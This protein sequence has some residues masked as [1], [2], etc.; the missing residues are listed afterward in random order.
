MA[1]EVQYPQA[2]PDQAVQLQEAED[3]EVPLR[4][5][6]QG[7]RPVINEA[8]EP[9]QDELEVGKMSINF[10]MT[11]HVQFAIGYVSFIQVVLDF[12]LTELI[13]VSTI[14]TV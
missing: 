6:Q 4:L 2:Q 5:P 13:Y 3:R 9:Q 7:P 11:V 10:N 1:D 12:C 14:L 8:Q